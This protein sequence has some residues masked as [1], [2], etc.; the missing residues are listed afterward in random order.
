VQ[1]AVVKPELKLKIQNILL[2]IGI[3]LL[4]GLLYNYLF[5]PHSLT[6]YL[7]AATISILIGL[8]LGILEE[9]VLKQVF[10]RISFL[11][12]TI[13][14]SILYSLLISIILAM[15]LSIETSFIEEISYRQ[16]VDQYL[17]GP[18]FQRDFLFSFLFI[19][20]ILIQFQFI[21]LIGKRNFFRMLL[22]LYHRPREVRRIFM[23]LDLKGSTTIAEG[24][25]NK[26]YSSLV[27]D[28]FYDVSDA[29][30]MFNGEIYQ[31]VGDEIVVV[32]PIRK[33]NE[34]CIRCFFKI[35]AIIEQKRDKYRL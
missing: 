25:E 20:L 16:A 34:D 27:Q 12:V 9:S 3:G 13:I 32:W 31:Y 1:I 8:I 30:M 24:L 15:V 21:Q 14:R 29:I 17:T 6:E 2:I 18:L 11:S 22:G 10:R 23:F 28:F 33:S 26:A 35:V 19:V 4:F 7:E 5:Y